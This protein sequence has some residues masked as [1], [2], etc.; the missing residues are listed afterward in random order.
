MHKT[1]FMVIS[2]LALIFT[3]LNSYAANNAPLDHII[4]IVND[5]VITDREMRHE[6][7]RIKKRI[8]TKT[9]QTPSDDVLIGQVLESMITLK[10]QKQKASTLG[11]H[12]DDLTLNKTM[13]RAA[14]D[15]KMSLEQFRLAIIK[16]GSNYE[17]FRERMRT[18]ITLSRL[19]KQQ[20]INRIDISE[21]EVDEFLENEAI[22]GNRNSEYQ[23]SHI[24]IAVP[25]AASPEIIKEKKDKAKS[26]LSRLQTGENFTQIAIESSDGEKALNG[27]ELGWLKTAE[28]PTLFANSVTSMKIGDVSKILRSP[29]GFHLIKLTNNRG[30]QRVIIKQTL[31]RHI[32]IK[33]NEL[34]SSDQAREKL[35]Q[36]R[37]RIIDG[38]SFADL[39]RA[40]S[41]D[42]GSGADGGHLKWMDEGETVPRFNAMLKSLPSKQLSEPFR[43][44]FGWHILEVL[45]HRDR[46]NTKEFQRGQVRQLLANRKSNEQLKL[47]LR[48]LR[49]EAYVEYPEQLT[50][51]NS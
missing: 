15:N 44:Q 27:G 46:D 16:D 29:N 33:P 9:G 49:D 32:L 38:D 17:K 42:K 7:G 14:A 51:E 21:K 50:A 47:W 24:L 3:G 36:L 1:T 22:L 48:G 35:Q 31:A 45:D 41:D 28:L 26:L 4:A 20:V 43:S 40:H 12:V 5:D 37:N 39:A 11:I 25:E 10:V 8:Q 6:L 2:T 18:E 13:Q 19:K 34:L 30:E 23:L